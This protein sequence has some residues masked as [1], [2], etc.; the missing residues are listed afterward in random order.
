MM[1]LVK[2]ASKEISNLYIGPY[3]T[4]KITKHSS[5]KVRVYIRISFLGNIRKRV[6]EKLIIEKFIPFSATCAVSEENYQKLIE[7]PGLEKLVISEIT[8]LDFLRVL[9]KIREVHGNSLYAIFDSTVEKLIEEVQ[10]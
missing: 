10:I 3:D 9:K 1:T 6:P 4:E 2:D 8:P 7:L 5:I